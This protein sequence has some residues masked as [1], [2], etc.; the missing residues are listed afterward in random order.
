MNQQLQTI[1][2]APIGPQL[3]GAQVT[4]SATT[5]GGTVTFAATL[6]DTNICTVSGNTAT[7][8]GPGSCTISVSQAG[9]ATYSPV[10]TS[11][12]FTVNRQT[13]TITWTSIGQQ[14]VGAQLALSATAPGGTVTFAATA[15]D[16]GIC[17]VSST[18]A[19]MAGA[20]SCTIT[21]SQAGSAMY[22]PA[23]TSQTFTVTQPA[24]AQ[25]F[26]ITPIPGSETIARG[27][28]AGS[29]SSCNR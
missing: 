5:P 12:T 7:M 9:N 23:S 2:W 26:T 29:F 28:L 19:N 25:N 1:T 24:P 10:S 22:A 11:Q 21:A 14:L 6:S 16:T 27:V 20:G 13:Q 17:T 8:T 18:T 3:V 4:L 15:S